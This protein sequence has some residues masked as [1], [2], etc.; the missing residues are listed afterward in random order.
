MCLH[1]HTYRQDLLSGIC[2]FLL[3]TPYVDGLI[4][5]SAHR[6][7]KR[8]KARPCGDASCPVDEG[9]SIGKS[10]NSSHVFPFFQ[11]WEWCCP[12]NVA[13]PLK[14]WLYLMGVIVMIMMS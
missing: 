11:F 6:I 1:I 5:W 3:L 2:S 12:K 10:P 8:R 13:F 4:W 14:L 7:A 9:K